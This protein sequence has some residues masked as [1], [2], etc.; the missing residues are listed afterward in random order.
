MAHFPEGGINGVDWHGALP[1]FKLLGAGRRPLSA[2]PKAVRALPEKAVGEA[3]A[4]PGKAGQPVAT[5]QECEFT[6]VSILGDPEPLRLG[7]P[8]PFLQKRRKGG[9]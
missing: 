5:V 9:R 3:R 6:V 8:C 7:L 2:R 1:Q 4:A